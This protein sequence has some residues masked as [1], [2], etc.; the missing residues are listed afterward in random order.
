M[1]SDFNEEMKT[2]RIALINMPMDSAVRPSIQLGILGAIAEQE[3]VETEH[4][5]ANIDLAQLIGLDFYE[6]LC[7]VQEAMVGEWL[8]SY[9]AFG[10]RLRYTTKQFVKSFSNEVLS[11]E[12]F[13]KKNI[14]LIN[15]REIVIPSFLDSL[16]NAYDWSKF[17]FI[18]FTSTFQ[19]NLGSLAL[20][21]R[22][23]KKFPAAKILMG[24][25]NLES[26]MGEEIFKQCGEIDFVFQGEA[27]N[28][29]RHFL[30]LAK[31]DLLTGQRGLVTQSENSIL[32]L[33]DKLQVD[34]DDSPEPD[35]VPYFRKISALSDYNNYRKS[36]IIPF[37][38]SRG[39]WWGQKKHCTFC[40][41]NGAT[42]AYRHKSK[43]KILSE[44]KN[45][46]GKYLWSSFIAVDNIVDHNFFDGLFE[47]IN[48]QDLYFKIF[49]EIKSNIDRHGLE[50]LKKGGVTIVQP[51]IESLST[52]VLRLM[53]KGCTKL[54]NIRCLKWARYYN[55]SVMWNI[56]YGFPGEKA[57]YYESQLRAVKVIKHLQ[58]PTVV[59]RLR[60]DRFSPNY[61]Q[62]K[63]FN[64]LNVRP[65]DSYSFI[66]PP[67]FDLNKI[68]YFFDYECP[69]TLPDSFH[70]ELNDEVSDWK[71]KWKTPE[72]KPYLNYRNIGQKIIIDQGDQANQRST[73]VAGTAALMYML[74]CDTFN[75]PSAIEKILK[76]DYAYSISEYDIREML[77]VFCESGFMECDGDKYLSLAL[78]A[79]NGGVN[80]NREESA[81][82]IF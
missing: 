74:C 12:K 40:G 49:Y 50:K 28:T 20:I 61:V 78:P 62:A 31:K 23:K 27:E 80:W 68:A 48:N 32:P 55:L 69:T 19:Q 8:L 16:V 72:T 82:P 33:S 39:C 15:L 56:L 60:L 36:V 37:E 38:S 47:E 76:T 46:S 10:S 42:M 81:E 57:E 52:E 41:L 75:S 30:K 66:Y 79:K 44:L 35:Y 51:G 59:T 25:S 70:E 53:R 73:Y 3:G 9:A 45:M 43:E 1:I 64:I 22:I 58:P 29:F 26:E 71:E 34:M 77:D 21:H 18:A 4:I 6:E 63:N 5:Y 13:D 14:G 54:H 67:E 17:D 24:G 2:L 65:Q 11:L 7:E